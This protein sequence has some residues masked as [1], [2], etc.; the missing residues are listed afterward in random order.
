MQRGL[1]ETEKANEALD[2]LL[3]KM[4]SAVEAMSSVEGELT[5]EFIINN[6]IGGGPET[7]L[8]RRIIKYQAKESAI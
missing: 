8:G 2:E 7:E 5:P 1:R 6:M 4:E 3:P